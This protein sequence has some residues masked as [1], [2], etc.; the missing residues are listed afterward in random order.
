MCIYHWFEIFSLFKCLVCCNL[1]F[2][3][4]LTSF[5]CKCNQPFP[6]HSLH[7]HHFIHLLLF[8]Y[9][10]YPHLVISSPLLHLSQGMLISISS[11][12]LLGVV[13]HSCK[14]RNRG[15]ASLERWLMVMW[16]RN[17]HSRIT[18]VKGTRASWK[19]IQNGSQWKLKKSLK[20]LTSGQFDYPFAIFNPACTYF[21]FF[22]V[23]ISATDVIIL[24]WIMIW[25]CR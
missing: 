22:S 21:S 5:S 24:V 25:L 18:G 23:S 17:W 14:G 12:V 20:Q 19:I 15:S 7:V 16:V 2:C 6:H 8:E 4:N 10:H 9:Q 13:A 11:L 1:W 3:N